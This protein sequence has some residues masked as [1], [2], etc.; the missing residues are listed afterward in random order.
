[1]AY[2]PLNKSAGDPILASDINAMSAQVAA[3]ETAIGQK[4]NA[5]DYAP[6]EKVSGMAQPVGKDAEGKLWTKNTIDHSQLTNR[7]AVEQHPISAITGLQDAL[8]GKQ[9]TEFVITITTTDGVNFT[10]DKTYAQY[11]AA[12]D[13][14]RPITIDTQA[15]NG[16]I[17]RHAGVTYMPG[18][19]DCLAA[20]IFGAM[21]GSVLFSQIEMYEG[22][23]GEI[24]M[25]QITL[26][27]QA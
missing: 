3:N 2:T 13:A 25:N 26:A 10:A 20:A 9:D 6:I 18:T 17:T 12:F 7:D 24:S 21:R 1:M 16:G 22:S 8:D 11:K 14:G 23:T 5:T 19:V 15:L 4:V 27:T